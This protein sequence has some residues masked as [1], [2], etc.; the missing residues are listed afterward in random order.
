MATASRRHAGSSRAAAAVAA[1]HLAVLQL[2]PRPTGLLRTGSLG[3][4]Q[5]EVGPAPRL[6]IAGVCSAPSIWRIRRPLNF[7][8]PFSIPR[9]STFYSKCILQGKVADEVVFPLRTT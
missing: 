2:P 6:P 7:R 3:W 1:P 9:N 4:Q 5:R 8:D